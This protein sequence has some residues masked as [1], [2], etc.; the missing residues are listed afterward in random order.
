MAPILHTPEE[1]HGLDLCQDGATV[2][3]A[4]KCLPLLGLLIGPNLKS[5]CKLYCNLYV[6]DARMG[7]DKNVMFVGEVEDFGIKRDVSSRIVLQ[8]T[9]GQY[10]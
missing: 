9:P 3:R 2:Q 10:R 8:E 1:T 6:E 4:I 7:V 5:D